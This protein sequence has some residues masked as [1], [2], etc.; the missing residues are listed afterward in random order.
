MDRLFH[1]SKKQKRTLAIIAAVVFL[2]FSVV[3]YLGE[4]G[5]LPFSVPGWDD[6][7]TYLGLED[8]VTGATLTG[9]SIAGVCFI[10]AGQADSTLIMTKEKTVLIDAGEKD[11]A[12]A[13]CEY[14][15]NAG[16]EKI[17]LLI[18]THPHSDHI[19]GTIKVM[20]SFV[21]DTVMLPEMADAVVPTTN[22]FSQFLSS[23]EKH[24]INAVTATPG[25]TYTL[26]ENVVLTILGPAKEYDNLND[27]SV[28]CRL[29]AGKRSFLFM[30]DAET[31]VENDLLAAGARLKADVLKL[32]HHGSSTS[33]SQKFLDAVNPKI[34]V[35]SCG[36][37][38]SYGHPHKEIIKRISEMGATLYRTDTD[39]NILIQTDGEVLTVDD[40]AGAAA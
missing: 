24:K 23:V 16:V 38:N 37:N 8:D 30:G 12:A 26:A 6:I 39:G 22:L 32:G 25:E 27:V 15:K 28:V 17:D 7:F 29:D 31:P 14:L 4:E 19:G 3:I 11:S 1:L 9:Q 5:L 34:A 20:D 40:K 35:A 18:A 36:A 2:C 33:S 21:V 10:D 13:V